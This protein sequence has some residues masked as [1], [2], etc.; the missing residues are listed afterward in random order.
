MGVGCISPFHFL[1]YNYGPQIFLGTPLQPPYFSHAIYVTAQRL[2]YFIFLVKDSDKVIAADDEVES[3]TPVVA[4]D[5]TTSNPCPAD[6]VVHHTEECNSNGDCIRRS[7]NDDI[8][9]VKVDVPL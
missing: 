1:S 6:V 2:F 3:I 9:D 5:S 8:S 7:T 4:A